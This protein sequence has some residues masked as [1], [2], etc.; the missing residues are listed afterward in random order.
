[1][2]RKT[3][4]A[5]ALLTAA[6]AMPL[7]PPAVAADA[8]KVSI[9]LPGV[10]PIYLTVF[11]YVADKQGFFKKYNAN[12]EL[13]QFDS[14]A[15]G[16][17]AVISGDVDLALVPTAL[18]IG[19][20]A[21]ANADVVSIY[22]LPN[23][24]WAIGTTDANKASCADIKGQP[25][26]V[27]TPGGARSLALKDM[28]VGGC[29]LTINDVQQVPLGS[30]TAPAMIAGQI[31]YGV[32]HLNDV[33]VIESQGKKVTLVMTLAK[34]VPISHYDVLEVRRD[35]LAEKRDAIVRT[36]A[37][38]V[39][40]ARYMADPKNADTVAQIGTVTG[41]TPQISKEALKLFNGIGF[42]EIKDDGLDQKKMEAVAEDQVKVGNVKDPK[43]LPSYER[44]VDR[45]VWKDANAMIG[46]GH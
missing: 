38:L 42:W 23:P 5:A 7:V 25:V 30:N 31:S 26:G 35:R 20:I 34:A 10:P 46:S 36:L 16:S 2:F 8:P 32:L 40:A 41:E 3:I 39:D 28:L 19:Q 22:G 21:N 4:V 24:D 1:M 14:G 27:D 33:P 6:A 12:V 29:H 15:A 13:R 44:L 37:A 18:T 11:A 17:R 45:S 43:K 9:A